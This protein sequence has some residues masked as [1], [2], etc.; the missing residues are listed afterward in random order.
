M[1]KTVELE[2][3]GAQQKYLQRETSEG[4]KEEEWWR[5]ESAELLLRLRKKQEKTKS[6]LCFSHTEL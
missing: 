5:L 2:Q 3:C 1:W 6:P 4:D